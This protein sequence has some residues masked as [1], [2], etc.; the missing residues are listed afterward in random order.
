MK[1]E[2][3][4]IEFFEGVPDQTEVKKFADGKHNLIILDDLSER[5][6]KDPV[7]EKLFVQGAHHLNLSVFFV[8]HN[9]FRQG[10]CARTIAL[11]TH[12]TILFRNV[13]DGQQ[14]G[15]LGKQMFPGNN[16]VLVEAYED[17]TST[18]YGYL[19]IDSTANGEDAYRLRT[20]IFPG[21]DPIVYVKL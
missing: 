21:E 7:I 17:A 2:I 6:V 14:I 15:S 5:V 9:C 16:K 8:S 1:K 20:K 18:K 10:K 4:G 19:V 3:E 13:R 11:N 12:Y